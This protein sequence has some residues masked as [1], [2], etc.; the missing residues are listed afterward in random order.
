MTNFMIILEESIKLM[1]DGVLEPTDEIIVTEDG[2][3]LQVPEAIHTYNKWKSLGFQVKRGEK[4]IAQFPIW[5]YTSKK[6]P[7]MTEEEAQQ[8]GFCFMKVSSFFKKSQVEEIKNER[9]IANT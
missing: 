1:E 2:V 7:D 4:S 6:N 8:K 3:E 5:K 9:S